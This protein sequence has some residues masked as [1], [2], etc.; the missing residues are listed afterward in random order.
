M[1][2]L[3]RPR[4]RSPSAEYTFIGGGPP[5]YWPQDRSYSP[6]RK[7]KII[8]VQNGMPEK[9]KK[10][11]PR[12]DSDSDT[13]VSVVIKDATPRSLKHIKKSDSD[14]SESSESRSRSREKKQRKSK[15]VTILKDS[16]KKVKAKEKTNKKGKEKKKKETSSEDEEEKTQKNIRFDLNSV[17]N[18]RFSKSKEVEVKQNATPE[19]DSDVSVPEPEIPKIEAK[20]QA[21]PSQQNQPIQ[22]ERVEVQASIDPVQKAKTPVSAASSRNHTPISV[23]SP[24]F[25][26]NSPTPKKSNS[27]NLVKNNKSPK[28]QDDSELLA[29]L[30][31]LD[32]R[33][34]FELEQLKGGNLRKLPPDVNLEMKKKIFSSEFQKSIDTF[35]ES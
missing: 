3:S 1:R 6:K 30:E 2:S 22:E 5:G 7:K 31:Q 16:K 14:D 25:L 24:D 20:I 29:A 19:P 26:R 34:D 13:D 4:Y 33:S 23:Q 9:K 15:N 21:T 8:I 11:N 10:R 32:K 18:R 28:P 12:F 27:P 35:L 17:K